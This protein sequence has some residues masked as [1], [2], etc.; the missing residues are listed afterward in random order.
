MVT[1]PNMTLTLE[2]VPVAMAGAAGGAVQ[3]AQ[4]I[5]AAIG[6]ASLVTIY[7][8]VLSHSSGAAVAA[9]DAVLSATGFMLL[10]LL[11]AGV[12]LARRLRRN[13]RAGCAGQPVQQPHH[14]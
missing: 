10:A 12:E 8:H 9:S 5:G 3:T 11:V 2:F 7:Y 4:R 1:S 13:R 14:I 6:T